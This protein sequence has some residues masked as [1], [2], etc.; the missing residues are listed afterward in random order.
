VTFGTEVG[1][2]FVR[3]VATVVFAVAE[4]PTRDTP[5]IVSRR[6]LLPTGTTVPIPTPVRRF[7]RIITAI[8]IEVTEPE[9]GNAFAVFALILR[10]FIALPRMTD[11][12]V[13][14]GAV[15]AVVIAVALPRVG[16]TPAG[17]PAFEAVFAA[18][19]AAETFVRFVATV[20]DTVADPDPGDTGV[21]IP[22]L[23]HSRFAH[24]GRAVHLIRPVPTVLIAVARPEDRY[25]PVIGRLTPVLP[26]RAVGNTCL[27]VLSE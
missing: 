12:R 13:L 25:T 19:G 16:D 10:V 26:F 20:G 11:R 3:I 15:G 9:F 27:I 24:K 7:V 2:T 14:I 4:E 18:I 5:V 22:A 21:V 17:G 23:K 1:I 8:V 6:T